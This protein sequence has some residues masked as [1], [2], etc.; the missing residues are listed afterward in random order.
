MSYKSIITGIVAI[1]TL[2]VPALFILLLKIFKV[3][4]SVNLYNRK[5]RLI[6][7]IIT[8][9]CY[10]ACA[11]LLYRLKVPVW[12]ISM[13]IG[14]SFSLI[15]CMFVTLIWKISAHGTGMGGIMAAVIYLYV[16]Y[17]MIP[18]W[19]LS[20][21]IL[22]AGAV[23]TAR[24]YLNCHTFGQ[25]MAGYANGLGWILLLMSISTYVL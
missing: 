13:L 7:Y 6:P 1:F 10:L 25:V 17:A 4:S 5:D 22:A 21:V 18:L 24:I 15:T 3:I 19:A 16:V 8:I 12:M 14:A 11:I 9:L 23:G 20:L 2:V